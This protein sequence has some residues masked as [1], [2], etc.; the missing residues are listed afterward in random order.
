MGTTLDLRV[1]PAKQYSNFFDDRAKQARDD[2]EAA[3]AKLSA[4]QQQKGLMATDERLDVEN[5]R[6]QE[7]TTQMVALQAIANES[8]SRQGQMG[9][10]ANQMSEVLNNGLIASL[11]GDLARQEAPQF[12]TLPHAPGRSQFRGG[13]DAVR[14]QLEVV[15]ELDEQLPLGVVAALDGVVQVAGGVAEV[16]RLHVGGVLLGHADTLYE[17]RAGPHVVLADQLFL[18]WRLRLGGRDRDRSGTCEVSAPRRGAGECPG[19]R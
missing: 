6:L 10:N 9:G 12:R 2:L 1:E 5:S 14:Q 19:R 8:S 3:Q 13:E 11:K 17:P 4:Y 15:H 7:L 18:G 16:V